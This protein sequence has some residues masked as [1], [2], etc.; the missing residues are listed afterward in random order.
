MAPARQNGSAHQLILPLAA[1]GNLPA[2]LLI[3]MRVYPFKVL[4]LYYPN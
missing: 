2:S 4:T 3:A 1:S